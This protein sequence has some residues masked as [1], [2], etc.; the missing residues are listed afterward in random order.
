MG[1][2]TRF[3][4]W[5]GDSP[6]FTSKT[7]IY[8][9]LYSCNYYRCYLTTQSLLEVSAALWTW[10]YFR[11]GHLTWGSKGVRMAGHS[12]RSR[13]VYLLFLTS[14]L[15]LSR[16]CGRA[17]KQ[18]GAV[19]DLLPTHTSTCK[20]GEMQRLNDHCNKFYWG[21]SDSLYLG[22][23]FCFGTRAHRNP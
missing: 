15:V 6:W 3:K 17:R 13:L 22:A 16:I 10:Y 11:Y 9:I 14:S 5:K 23:N 2:V 20:V 12:Q 1:S 21:C 8:Y 4:M 19:A 18:R 7:G